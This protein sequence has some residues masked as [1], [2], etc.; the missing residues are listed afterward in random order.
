MSFSLANRIR[1]N[2][3]ASNLDIRYGPWL[4]EAAAKA[5]IVEGL[6]D[7]G[8]TVGIYVPNNDTNSPVVEYWWKDG[9]ADNNL[10]LKTTG[11]GGGTDLNTVTNYLSTNNV[12]LSSSNITQKLVASNLEVTNKATQGLSTTAA[13]NY[14]FAG[15]RA[16]VAAEDYSWFWHAP[17]VPYLPGPPLSTTRQGQFRVR[18]DGGIFLQHYVGIGTDSMQNA[19]TVNGTISAKSLIVDSVQ[20]NIVTSSGTVSATGPLLIGSSTQA[21]TG[22]GLVVN[23]NVRINGIDISSNPLSTLSALDTDGQ[24]LFDLRSAAPSANYNLSIASSGVG[25]FMKFFGGRG[26]DEKPFIVV[27]TG[28]PLRF[29]SFSNYYNSSNDF[30]EHVR[31]N[32]GSGNVVRLKVFGSVE[33]GQ[34]TNASGANSHAEGGLTDAI[35]SHSHAEGYDTVATGIYSH[36]ENLQT[37]AAGYASH[38]EGSATRASGLASHAEGSNT[39]ASGNSSHAEGGQTTASGAVSHAE[40]SETTASNNASHAEGWSTTASGIASHSQGQSTLAS[41]DRS[42]AEGANTTASGAVSHAEGEFTNAS[43][44]ASHAE[45]SSTQAVGNRSHAEGNSTRASGIE[46]HSEGQSTKA[47]GNWSHAEGRQ[48]IALGATSHS[49]NINTVACG[50]NSHAEGSF[51][52]TG[53]KVAFTNYSST[54]RTFT[55]SSSLSSRFSYVGGGTELVGINATNDQLFSFVVASRNT[56][57]G[58]ISAATD[59]YINGQ[60]GWLLTN[61]GINSHAEGN[62]TTASGEASHAEGSNTSAFGVASH[63][64]GYGVIASGS[65]SHAEGGFTTA[66]GGSSHAEG[67]NTQAIGSTSHAEGNSTIASNTASH[68]EGSGTIASGQ[69]SHAEGVNTRAFGTAS[70]ASGNLTIARGAYSWAGG[71]GCEA[72]H[73]RSWI[74]KGSVG[75]ATL[76]STRSDQFMVSAA[77]G[78]AFFGNIG[79][80]TDSVDRALT[81]VGVASATQLASLSSITAPGVNTA[82]L[83]LVI[84]DVAPPSRPSLA[85]TTN[86]VDSIVRW[87]QLNYNTNT[88]ILS[89]DLSRNAALNEGNCNILIQRPGT[90]RAEVRYSSYDLVS[91]TNFLRLQL[92][93]S[94]SGV[95][96]TA[97]G[98]TLLTTVEQGYVGTSGNGE[99][100]KSGVVT[101][102]VPTAPYWMVATILHS[103]ANGGNGNQGYPVFINNFGAQPYFYLERISD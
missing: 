11:S 35:G 19:L 102:T 71:S 74:W 64:E 29:A 3:K 16:A 10:V 36:T 20:Q 30:L 34:S 51:S 42:H 66:S 70:H 57:T 9:T 33:E 79:I 101:F 21:L 22:N 52:V 78:S 82:K 86:G 48:S 12:L 43:G 24:S 6:R 54:T 63:A 13:G 39:I 45:G 37:S 40:G 7:K 76:S 75:T 4:N 99:A 5:G 91:P 23:G 93:F 95:I 68:A 41:G 92:R 32:T 65:S 56:N 28:S 2:N 97:S 62:T 53:E 77:G 61:S 96:T 83:Q 98:G 94:T 26:G 25:N 85:N 60:S 50:A 69:F 27:K 84:G 17:S 15:G 1:I 58:E 44:A 31:I 100:M 46:S 8:L 87:N 80:G 38:A 49:E 67:N 47:I 14:S 89:A 90:Y 18:A 55:F 81:V 72:V 59:A 88:S 73:D 103:G